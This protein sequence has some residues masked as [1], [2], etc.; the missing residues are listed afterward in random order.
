MIERL[1][2][3]APLLRPLLVPF[4]LYIGLLVVASRPI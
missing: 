3:R 2:E 1:K 4:I